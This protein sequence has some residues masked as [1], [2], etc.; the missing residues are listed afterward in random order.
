MFGI[1]Y[2]NILALSIEFI[3]LSLFNIISTFIDYLVKKP[4]F[5]K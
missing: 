5:L 1:Q 2:M 4:P 3:L